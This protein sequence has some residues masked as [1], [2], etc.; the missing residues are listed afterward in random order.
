MTELGVICA[1]LLA[2]VLVARDAG[3][4]PGSSLGVRLLS[5]TEVAL[6]TVVAVVVL[7]TL[8][9]LVA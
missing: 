2:A 8:V 4:R 7:P 1:L 6:W 3:W 5:G 9:H